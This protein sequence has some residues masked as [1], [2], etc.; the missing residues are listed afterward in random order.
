MPLSS[1]QATSVVYQ[2]F[3]AAR[4]T[5]GAPFGTPVL[6]SELANANSSTVDGFLT[7]D[8]LTLFYSSPAAAVPARRRAAERRRNRHPVLG[9]VRG[10]ATIDERAV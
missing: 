2:T 8:G 7:D 9:P 5:T 6:V 3:L 4:A 1:K 10:V